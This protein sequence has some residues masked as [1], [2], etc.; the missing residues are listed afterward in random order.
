MIYSNGGHIGQGVWSLAEDPVIYVVKDHYIGS[1][2]RVNY[3]Q[4]KLAK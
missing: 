4:I 1:D 3:L 2:K